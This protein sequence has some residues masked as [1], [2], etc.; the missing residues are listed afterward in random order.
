MGA[1]LKAWRLAVRVEARG[2]ERLA[3]NPGAPIALWHGRIHG[4]VYGIVPHGRF[5]AMFS[6]S[7][8]GELAARC[9]APFGLGAA[10]GSTGK[11]GRRAL[12]ELLDW[13]RR[14]VIDHPALTVDGPRGPWRVVKPGVV[15]L[16]RALGR[17]VLPVSFSATRVWTLRSWDRMVLACPFARVVAAVGEPVTVAP[18]E[19][20][21]IA[22]ARVAAALDALTEALDL[23]LAG[24]RLWPPAIRDAA[25][26][27]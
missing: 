20:V 18:D 21:E 12:D 13:V 26:P 4:S 3:G 10:R 15:E 9:L 2:L 11:G 1:V 5:A 14:G 7:A 25:P 17:P 8:D 19:P 24:R 23:E 6:R 16:A 27:R 22:T